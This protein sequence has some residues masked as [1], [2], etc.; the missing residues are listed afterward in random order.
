MIEMAGW[1]LMALAL[2]H[3]VF[4]SYF[5]WKKELASLS[6]IN[7]QLMEVH[8]FFVAL[9]V[10]MMGLLCVTSADLLLTSELGQRLLLGMSFFWGIRLFVQFLWYSPVLWKG[11]PFETLVHIS[12]S[13][14]WVFLTLLFAIAGFSS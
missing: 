7:R 8:A 1:L 10:W 11:K 12:F 13:L 4:P 3:V 6:L 9:M 14:L 5:R 2:V